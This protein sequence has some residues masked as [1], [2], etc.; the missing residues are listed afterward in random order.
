LEAA[1]SVRV[2]LSV[3]PRGVWD[4]G[5]VWHGNIRRGLRIPL[6]EHVGRSLLQHSK[7]RSPTLD[8]GSAMEMV[9]LL[10]R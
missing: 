7:S 1:T 2:C 9:H 10:G 4:R 6:P 5:E 3:A 8:G